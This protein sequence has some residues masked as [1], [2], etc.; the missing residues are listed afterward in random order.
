MSAPPRPTREALKDFA[1]GAWGLA[2]RDDRVAP[3]DRAAADARA[4]LGLPDDAALLARLRAG[5]PAA[6]ARFASAIT[7]GETYLFRHAAHF[8]LARAHLRALAAASPG[9]RLRL[10]SAGCASGEEAWSLAIAAREALG[11]EGFARVEVLGTDLHPAALERARAGRYG[12]WSF[13]E[14][15]AP[16]AR[17]FERDGDAWRV[18]D[19][20]RGAVAFAPLNLARGA[21][22]V[23]AFDVVFCRNVLLY[24][25]AASVAR[26]ASL[27]AASLAPDGLLVPGPADPA[28]DG[29]CPLGAARVDGARVY[30]HAAPD[31]AEK[32]APLPA[33]VRASPVLPGP[34]RA[35]PVAPPVPAPATPADPLDVAVARDPLDAAAWIRRALARLDQCDPQGAADDA[36]RAL[37]LDRRSP[38]A[39]VLAAMAALASG[40]RAA[41][42]RHARNAGTLLRGAPDDA[43]VAHAEGETAASLRWLCAQLGGAA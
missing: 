11:A 12:R 14:G 20:L 34:V 9:R 19:E 36:H 3:I 16:D 26:A 6:V 40:D 28:L 23:G 30:R 2:L 29:L 35:L 42:R 43:A 37:L 25:D 17:W 1:R 21:G 15:Y 38:F 5:D 27:L 31:V 8:E 4:A 24:F 33:I 39:H 10:W 32:P 18:R 13:R 22:P 7:V 41:A